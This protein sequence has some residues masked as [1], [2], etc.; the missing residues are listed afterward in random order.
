[1]KNYF[2]LGFVPVNS[3]LNSRL[4]FRLK[5]W[6]MS[7]ILSSLILCSVFFAPSAAVAQENM[8]LRFEKNRPTDNLNDPE[9]VS[10]GA[11]SLSEGKVGNF[12]IINF[13]SDVEGKIWGFDFG[14][15]YSF[16]SRGSPLIMYLGF[17]F[18]LGYNTDQS[19]Y[20]AGYYPSAGLVYSI[21]QGVG[22]TASAKRYYNVYDD[23]IDAIMVG[24]VLKY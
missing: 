10:L 20:I 22:V 4:N 5:H 2:K 17:G 6:A 9:I 21:K 12:D 3:L 7:L 18:M 14:L 1:M 11:F 19:D 16:S 23:S 13:K 15:G 8:L 24:V